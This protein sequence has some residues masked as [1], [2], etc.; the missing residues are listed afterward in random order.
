MTR[1]ATL[2]NSRREMITTRGFAEWA[3]QRSGPANNVSP[4][5]AGLVLDR[6]R[7]PHRRLYHNNVMVRRSVY[8]SDITDLAAIVSINAGRYR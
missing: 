6:R 2:R 7:H 5:L 3:R 4:D 1:N 8:G